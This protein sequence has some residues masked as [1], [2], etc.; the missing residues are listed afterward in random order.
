MPRPCGPGD[1]SGFPRSWNSC[2]G[3]FCGR[4]EVP[5]D[6]NA[7][8]C[9][10]D[11]ASSGL[12]AL[13]NAPKYR[14]F[15]GLGQLSYSFCRSF[16]CPKVNI[17][18]QMYLQVLDV[19]REGGGKKGGKKKSQDTEVPARLRLLL[20]AGFDGKLLN[21]IR[22]FDEKKE[23]KRKEILIPMLFVCVRVCMY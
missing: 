8:P 4:G 6:S 18:T 12:R 5:E 23:K 9:P 14:S 3:E 22:L 2:S 11:A 19:K 21:W 13:L 20:R 1:P 16:Y 15:T 10:E 17:V 7:R